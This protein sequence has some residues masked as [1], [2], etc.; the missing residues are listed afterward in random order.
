[1]TPEAHGPGARRRGRRPGENV[2]RQ[3]VLDAARG[4]FAAEGYAGASIRAIAGDAGVDAALVMRFFGSKDGLFSA[5]MVIPE[6]GQE[7]LARA[8]DGPGDA[9]GDRL[10]RAFLQ[11]FIETATATPM[12]AIVRSAVTNEQAA[13]QLRTFIRARVLEVFA[14]RFPGVAD[15]PLRATLAAS[16]LLG[17]VISREVVQ[18]DAL[19]DAD[20]ETIVAVTAP[21]IQG[22]L[23]P[24]GSDASSSEDRG[25]GRADRQAEEHGEG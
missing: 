6:E 15:A 8:L 4:R 10:V 2:T 7:A 11:L 12:L 16:A 9:V 23:V 24:P 20:F 21:L 13:E 3:A 5:A 22:V 25:E 14:P 1:M 17:I 18:V 19:R